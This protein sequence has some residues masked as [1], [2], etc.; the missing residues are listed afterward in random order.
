LRAG[1]LAALPALLACCALAAGLAGRVAAQGAAAAPAR[2]EIR[3]ADLVVVAVLQGEELTARVSRL[4]DNAPV[5]D[6]VVTVE[7]RGAT[8]PA[9]AQADGS[10]TIQASEL[11]LPGPV[12]VI[13]HVSTGGGEQKLLGTLQVAAPATRPDGS[14]NIRQALWWVLNFAVCG[15]FLVLWARRRKRADTDS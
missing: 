8:H 4:L 11:A 10:Y 1:L 14:G 12:A 9:L 13:F 3:S 6:A 15:G 5:R 2:V 7:F